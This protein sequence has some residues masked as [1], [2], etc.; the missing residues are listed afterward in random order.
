MADGRNEMLLENLG[1]GRLI[2]ISQNLGC[3]AEGCRLDP[4]R[5]AQAAALVDASLKEGIDVLLLNRFGR[6]EMLGG[7][8]F[9]M[10][11]TAAASGVP[12]ITPVNRDHFEQ[13]QAFADGHAV[14]LP[15]DAEAIARW[16]VEAASRLKIARA[17]SLEAARHVS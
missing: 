10:L 6:A 1:T 12:V 16:C 4:G 3:G 9:D 5:L 14:V 13:W 7:G 17:E 15:L 2:S 11:A 8:L